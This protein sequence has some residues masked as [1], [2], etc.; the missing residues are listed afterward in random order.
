MPDKNNASVLLLRTHSS[1]KLEY[2]DRRILLYGG[3]QILLKL[4]SSK[5]KE[6]F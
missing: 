3:L 5:T 2:L 6:F 1:N 4:S